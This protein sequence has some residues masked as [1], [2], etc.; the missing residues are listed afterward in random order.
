MLAFVFSGGLAQ[1]KFD[2]S[3]GSNFLTNFLCFNY[4]FACVRE[5]QNLDFLYLRIYSKK[6]GHD[7]SA[8]FARSIYTLKAKVLGRVVPYVGQR[9]TLNQK[10]LEV[11]KPI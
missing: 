8:C 6:G 3:V 5:D 7:E 9:T 11:S 10:G 2:L 4:Q 1:D